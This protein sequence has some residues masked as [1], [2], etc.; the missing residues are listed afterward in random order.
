MTVSSPQGKRWMAWLAGGLLALSAA[1]STAAD[2]DPQR[3]GEARR[4]VAELAERGID[5]DW[6]EAAMQAAEYRQ[7]VLDAM[8]G[9]AEHRL[10]WP[11]YRAIFLD[12]ARIANG[13][14]FIAAHPDAFARAEADFGVPP[15]VIAAILGVETRYGEITGRHRVLDSLSTLAFH[16]PSRG[17]FFRGELAAFLEIAFEQQRAPGSLTG[18]Y[19]G[20]MGYPQF[21]PTSY[22]AYAVDFDDDGLRD[23]WTNPVDAIGSVGNYFAEHGWRADAPIYHAVEGPAAPPEGIEFNRAARPPAVPAARLAASG[24]EMPGALADDHRLLPVALEAGE[25]TWRY[26]L[27]EQNFYVITRYNHSHLYAMA[28]TELAEAIAEARG[29]KA[30]WLDAADTLPEEAS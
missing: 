27:G 25:G 26:V 1:G 3:H 19:A 10:T 17:R 9:A 7:S 5:R 20:A 23:L 15:E 22:R 6:L 18:S 8:S 21:I 16:H 4:L 12:E 13:A 24:L 29:R 2:F 30:G 14:A 11:E 28:V